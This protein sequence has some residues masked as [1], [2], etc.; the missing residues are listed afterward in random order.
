MKT[1][2]ETPRKEANA[3]VSSAPPQPTTLPST[4]R[5]G[6]LLLEEDRIAADAL[7]AAL[8]Q[9]A[10][11]GGL[12]GEILVARKALTEPE[13]YRTLARQLGLAYREQ[14]GTELFEE[15]IIAK[16]N[17]N[18]AKRFGLLPLAFRGRRL[19][20]LTSNPLAYEPLDDIARL[21]GRPVQPIVAP[22]A[23]IRELTNRFY[24][25]A[26]TLLGAEVESVRTEEDQLGV[27]EHELEEI[28]DLLDAT[29]EA[30]IIRYVNQLLFQA[31][32]E[33]ASDIHIEPQEKELLVRFRIDGIL[34]V[35]GHP[36]K[37]FQNAIISRVKVMAN[38]D[39]A[40]KRLPQD[41]R[42][43][44]KLAG[45]D[46]DIRVSIV[47]TQ[48]GEKVVLR[49]LDKTNILLDL[50]DIGVRPDKLITIERLIK[51]SHG[52]ILVTGPTGSGKTTTLY[53]CLNKI[54]GPGINITTVEDPVEYQLRGIGQIQVNDKI[55]LTFANGLRS[56]LRQDPDVIMVGEI[57]DTETAEMAIQ[58]SLTGHLVF[59][60]LHTNDSSGAI[61]RLVDMGVEPFLISSTLLAVIAQRLIRT[62]CPECRESYVPR[63]LELDEIV[64]VRKALRDGKVFRGRGCHACVQTGYRGRS[65]IYEI[66]LVDEEIQK[67]MV[68]RSSSNLIKKA[69][70]LAG[71]ISL[72]QD[73]AAKVL[74]GITS[75]EEILR[76]TQEETFEIS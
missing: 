38:L 20:V 3:A 55:D 64:L 34:Y 49:L 2:A 70:M 26:A 43:R 39:I 18:F 5:L 24:D 15:V 76:V 67:L 13:L 11:K 35:K 30:P 41:G 25:Q 32:K 63:D 40:E 52:I 47:P 68:T 51:K 44:I 48:F 56:I 19:E 72:R 9:Q 12:I 59:S 14:G 45:R 8:A 1:A 36:Q 65:G 27:V 50:Q 74:E 6:E 7:E 69:G 53:A 60:T 10:E 21:Y 61:A 28:A 66:L 57:R 58:A 33:R 75:I 17:I 42:I 46:I 73:G 22:P 16:L 37:R 29:D 4:K 71:M 54:N 62:I 31:V 23:F